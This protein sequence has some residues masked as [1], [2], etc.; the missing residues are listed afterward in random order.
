MVRPRP[1]TWVSLS[2]VVRDTVVPIRRSA[3]AAKCRSG[4]AENRLPP[5]SS[6]ASMRP[7]AA[8]STLASVCSPGAAGTANP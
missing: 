7:S 1:W 3:A 5:S 6:A 8:A 4:V 2:L